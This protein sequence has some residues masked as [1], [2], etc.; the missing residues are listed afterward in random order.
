MPISKALLL[1]FQLESAYEVAVRDMT[2]N[3]I[4]LEWNNVISID[5][6]EQSIAEIKVYHT[7]FRLSLKYA[8]EVVTSI[9]SFFTNVELQLRTHGKEV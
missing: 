3:G 7:V 2:R 8:W 5:Q 1:S 6:I 9:H 4:D